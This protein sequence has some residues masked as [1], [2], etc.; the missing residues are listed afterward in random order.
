MLYELA[1]TEDKL[2]WYGPFLNYS[3]CSRFLN[4]NKHSAAEANHS[5]LAKPIKRN[6][7]LEHLVNTEIGKF[8]IAYNP[9]YPPFPSNPKSSKNP[10][11]VIPLTTHGIDVLI[12]T[13]FIAVAFLRIVNYHLTDFH[14]LGFES[15]ILYWH[16]VDII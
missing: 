13:I 7:N 14:H 1:F 5:N 12:G 11:K 15:S 10:L 9:N 6:S 8:Y 3:S 16:F 2:N 4:P